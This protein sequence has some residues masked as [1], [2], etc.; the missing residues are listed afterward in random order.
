MLSHPIFGKPEVVLEASRGT[1]RQQGAQAGAGR[2]QQ[3]GRRQAGGRQAGRQLYWDRAGSI[4]IAVPHCL[5]FAPE[6]PHR[7]AMASF[8]IIILDVVQ[9][10]R[11]IMSQFQRG[12]SP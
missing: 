7:R 8:H 3:A 2:G 5:R 12:R 11:K 10:E 1:G 9:Y 6:S 4:C